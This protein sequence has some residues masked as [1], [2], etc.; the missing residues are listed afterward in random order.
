MRISAKG[1]VTIPREIREQL[2]L[3]PETEVEFEVV[4][5]VVQMRRSE[6]ARVRGRRLIQGL[7][8]KASAGVRTDEILSM[9]RGED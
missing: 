8:G 7:S 6:R 5:N 1:Q 2:G 4:D 9:T 3:V